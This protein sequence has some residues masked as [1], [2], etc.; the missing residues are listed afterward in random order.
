MNPKPNKKIVL[1]SRVLRN[2]C[3]EGLFHTVPSSFVLHCRSRNC[4][5]SPQVYLC[6]FSTLANGITE[7][8]FITR[9]KW[10]Y[11]LFFFSF[12]FF[13]LSGSRKNQTSSTE[14]CTGLSS[15]SS[16]LSLPILYSKKYQ[17]ISVRSCF[18]SVTRWSFSNLYLLIKY[19]PSYIHFSLFN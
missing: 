18:T 12:F 15:D 6:A 10:R 17:Q 4:T 8:R 9:L 7:V 13:T 16:A 2:N 1:R 11:F 19:K 5:L 3:L 14:G